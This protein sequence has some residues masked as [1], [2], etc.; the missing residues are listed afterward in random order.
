MSTLGIEFISVLGLPPL[1]FVSL[2]AELGCQCIGIGLEPM[3]F[4]RGLHA[5]WSLRTDRELR[6]SLVAALQDRGITI[7]LG[8]GFLVRPGVDVRQSA[9]D[10]DLMCEIGAPRVNILTLDPDT[11]QSVEQ[12]GTFAELA[13]A[14]GLE[15]TLEFLPGLSVCDLISALAVVRQ[16][17]RPY[18]RVLIDAMHLYRSGGTAADVAAVDPGLIGYVQLCDVPRVSKTGNYADEA[19]FERLPPG[20]GELPLAELIAAVPKEVTLALEVPMVGRAKAGVPLVRSLAEC[21]A[22]TRA[23]CA[24]GSRER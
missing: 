2:A 6:R 17:N 4:Y 20:A 22:A 11:S 14:R 23:L 18:F 15:V 24:T 5:P 10:L 1:E 8:E 19:R 21:V 16:V 12:C 7:S 13:H 3:P 9:A